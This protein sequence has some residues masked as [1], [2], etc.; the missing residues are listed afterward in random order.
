MQ[1]FLS[2]LYHNI[3]KAL[4]ICIAYPHTWHENLLSHGYYGLLLKEFLGV[5]FTGVLV[6]IA[7]IPLLGQWDFG[8][9]ISY[10]LIPWLFVQFLVYTKREWNRV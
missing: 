2:S 7:M 9:I 8:R 5:A 6:S 4:R 10:G 1:K 3:L